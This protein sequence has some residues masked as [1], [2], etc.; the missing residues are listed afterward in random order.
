[1]RLVELTS[2]PVIKRPRGPRSPPAPAMD[3]IEPKAEPS[4]PNLSSLAVIPSPAPSISAEAAAQSARLFLRDFLKKKIFSK[5][6]WAP[7]R[8]PIPFAMQLHWSSEIIQFVFGEPLLSLRTEDDLYRVLPEVAEKH[9]GLGNWA[10]MRPPFVLKPGR[11]WVWFDLYSENGFLEP[12]NT[13][14]KG[15]AFVSTTTSPS[16][17]PLPLLTPLA[18][19]AGCICRPSSRGRTQE[20]SPPPAPAQRGPA[21]RS[22]SAACCP[23]C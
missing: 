8:K 13:R 18:L 17:Y 14:V 3:S 20:E 11:V 15:R 2:A 19:V 4:G 9:F 7:P 5:V 23:H 21:V 12:R 22:C 1:M 6:H 10:V 16:S